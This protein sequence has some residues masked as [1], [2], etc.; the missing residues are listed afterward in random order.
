M[1]VNSVKELKKGLASTDSS[2]ALGYILVNSE[3]TRSLE[4]EKWSLKRRK[5]F[6]KVNSSMER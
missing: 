3:V 2:L 1:R 5:W 4:K 6:T